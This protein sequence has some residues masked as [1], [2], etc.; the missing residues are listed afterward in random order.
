[1][2][3]I[4]DERDLVKL[5][6]NYRRDRVYL[7]P[8]RTTRERKVTM[9]LS[10]LRRANL[11]RAHPEFYNT[12]TNTCTTNLVEHVN[13]IVPEPHPAPT[14]RPASRRLGQARLRPRPDRISRCRSRK[15]EP[16]RRS[17]IWRGGSVMIRSSRY[18]FAN[19]NPEPA[20]EG[21]S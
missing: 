11:L 12:L 9:F 19:S 15:R 16:P 1:M 20:G 3:V 10:M 14:G 13:T 6:T 5:R 17:T 18:E 8:I 2:Y 4:G 7:Y 21:S